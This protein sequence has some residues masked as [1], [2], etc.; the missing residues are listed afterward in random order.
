MLTTPART[1]SHRRGRAS[2]RRTRVQ[3]EQHIG[4]RPASFPTTLLHKKERRKTHSVASGSSYL[5][6]G[7]RRYLRNRRDHSR[8]RLRPRDPHS[9]VPAPV[10]EPAYGLH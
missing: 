5:L 8:R 2:L 3:I 6:H 10:L 1:E 7:V 4:P 9:P